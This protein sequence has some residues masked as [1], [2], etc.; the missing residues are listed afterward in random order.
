MRKIKGNN[1]MRTKKQNETSIREVLYRFGPISRIEIAE[2]LSLT[3]PTITTSIASLIEQGIV[4]ECHNVAKE[5][6]PGTALGRRPIKIDFVST[7]QYFIGVELGPY[8]TYLCVLDLRGS[9]VAQ[10]KLAKA[11]TQYED[12]LADLADAIVDLWKS[13]KQDREKLMG[14]GVALPGFI[15][16]AEGVI[17]STSISSW[18]GKALAEDLARLT[19]FPVCIE[20]NARARAVAADLLSGLIHNDTFG[21]YLV[22]NGIA[23]PLMIKNSVLSGETSGAGEAGHMILELTGP[24]CDICGKHGCLDALASESAIRKKILALDEFSRPLSMK[25]ILVYQQQGHQ[26]ITKILETAVFYMGI[27]LANIINL[28]SPSTV[29]VD[30]MLF[31]NEANR[32][33]LVDTAREY[34]FGPNSTEINILFKPYEEEYGAVGAAAYAIRRFFIND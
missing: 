26:E 8:H 28:I 19:G 16:R 15:D 33:L 5:A 20:N 1:S 3:P 29:L 12:M 13:C 6:V 27:A 32:K 23:C 25:E 9:K 21:Y 7:S 31:S 17:M 11:S 4:E 2:L 34:M 30:G 18:Q 10:L 14:V 22:S 24:K